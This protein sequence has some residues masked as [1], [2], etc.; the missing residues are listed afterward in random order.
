MTRAHQHRIVASDATCFARACNAA[1]VTAVVA[2]D[3][4]HVGGGAE[5]PWAVGGSDSCDDIVVIKSNRAKEGNKSKQSVTI[6]KKIYSPKRVA[7]V[8]GG[9]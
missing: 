9:Q 4:D 1:C 6:T 7:G 3:D 5:T 8:V 2:A